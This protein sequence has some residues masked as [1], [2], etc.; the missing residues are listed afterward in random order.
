[1]LSDELWEI[2][3]DRKEQ[4][5]EERKRIMESGSVENNLDFLTSCAQS[6]LQSELDKF[7]TSIQIIHDYYFAI[8]EKTTHELTGAVTSELSFEGEEMP[9]VENMTEGSDSTLLGS[10]LYP[11]LDKLLQMALKQQAVPDVT[12]IDA[13]GA[14]K[15]GGK[16]PPAKKGAPASKDAEPDAPV[17]ESQY[18]KEMKEAVRVE[19]SL[20]R[21][22]LVQIRNWTLQRL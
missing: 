19:K 20:L 15:K 2:V 9:T 12:K 4:N 14:D 17:E 11:R 18:V 6:L 10:Y 5:I 21:F 1:M 3:E 16:A 13:S 22:R 8:E 7:K